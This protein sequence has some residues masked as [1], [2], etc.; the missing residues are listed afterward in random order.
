MKR[1]FLLALP[2]L[3]WACGNKADKTAA[4]D[5]SKTVVGEQDTTD[6]PESELP[7]TDRQSYYIWMA[8]TEAKTKKQNPVVHPSFYNVDTL[9][10]GL[11]EMYPQIRLEKS[12]I[13]HDTLYTKIA[14]ATYLTEQMGSAG[15]EQYIAQAVLNL[16]AVQGINFVRIDFEEGSHASPDVWSKNSFSDY[17]EVK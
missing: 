1:V 8:D 2:V 7:P 17:K 14:N 11:N 5:S 6:V 12:R 4:N 10:T 9:I 13:G 3:L 15:S 16:T